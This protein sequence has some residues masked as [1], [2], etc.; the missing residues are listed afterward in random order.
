MF[1]R[2]ADAG[3]VAADEASRGPGEHRPRPAC[4]RLGRCQHIKQHAQFY[5]V[6]PDNGSYARVVPQPLP[7]AYRRQL[8][9][10]DAANVERI[11]AEVGEQDVSGVAGVTSGGDERRLRGIPAIG[12]GVPGA[13]RGTRPGDGLFR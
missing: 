7:R 3:G 5:L 13:I 1:D 10:E 12:R 9:A 4:A 8:Q 11:V 2:S 6:G